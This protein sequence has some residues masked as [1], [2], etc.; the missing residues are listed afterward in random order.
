MTFTPHSAVTEYDGAFF[1]NTCRESWGAMPGSPEMPPECVPWRC[2]HCGATECTKH[3]VRRARCYEREIAALRAEVERLNQ[4]KHETL[5]IQQWWQ[6]VD[7]A[8]RARPDSLGRDVSKTA[9]RFIDER[10]ELK[11]EVAE[12]DRLLRDSVPERWKHATSPVACVQNYIAE[13][14]G[15]VPE[16]D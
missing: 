5:T 12:W 3:G 16:E 8:V 14:E 15:K 9:L 11:A 6:D 1:C 4:W 2:P 13:L 7:S 10:D